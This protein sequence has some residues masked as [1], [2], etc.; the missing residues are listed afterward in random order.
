MGIS[1][2]P[3]HKEGTQGGAAPHKKIQMLFLKE[4]RKGPGGAQTTDGHC[5]GWQLPRSAEED[6]HRD[7]WLPEDNNGVREHGLQD[8]PPPHPLSLLP[9][10]GSHP[11]G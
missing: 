6:G 4:G 1:S 3:H 9:V 10:H 11:A 8:P 7:K 5:G 2:L